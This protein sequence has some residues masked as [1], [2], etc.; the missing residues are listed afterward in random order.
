MNFQGYQI[1]AMTESFSPFITINMNFAKYD[2]K[3]QT[4]DVT[5]SVQGLYYDMLSIM[6]KYLN[7]TTT[8][9]KRKDGRWG[10]TIIL[11]NGTVQAAG[12]D[13]SVV[14]GYAEMI[15]TG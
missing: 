6:Q 1:K 13:E 12:I 7:F 5:Y 9:H 8:L 15:V 11:P 4:Y 2:E 3:S 14:S 10:P